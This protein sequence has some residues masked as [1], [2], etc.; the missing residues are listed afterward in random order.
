MRSLIMTSGR[1]LM[2]PS[3]AWEVYNT[4]PQKMMDSELLSTVYTVS[5]RGRHIQLLDTQSLCL[6][7]RA[8]VPG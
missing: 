8:Y 4:L 7:I 6:M 5:S 2:L 1:D 3:L